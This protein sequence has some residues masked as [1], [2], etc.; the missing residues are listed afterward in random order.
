MAN[1]KYF[2]QERI[3]TEKTDVVYQSEVG[4]VLENSDYRRHITN[5]IFTNEMANTDMNNIQCDAMEFQVGGFNPA[6]GSKYT[7]KMFDEETES[8]G[9]QINDI[10][11]DSPIRSIDVVNTMSRRLNFLD[12]GGRDCI[13]VYIQ[14][15]T[16][17]K[18][19]QDISA[20]TSSMFVIPVLKNRKQFEMLMK[21]YS[22]RTMDMATQGDLE[23]TQHKHASH[24]LVSRLAWVD[25]VKD[26][27]KPFQFP[28]SGWSVVHIDFFNQVSEGG[29]E[30]L[31]NL[32]KN[33][34]ILELTTYLVMVDK[35]TAADLYVN[36]TE[37]G[38]LP[39]NELGAYAASIFKCSEGILYPQ[40]YFFNDG[41]GKPKSKR[42]MFYA[43]AFCTTFYGGKDITKDKK[44]QKNNV[45]DPQIQL[46]FPQNYS[47]VSGG[48]PVTVE[49]QIPYP[50]KIT[51]I[52]GN[53]I[54]RLYPFMWLAREDS[55]KLGLKKMFHIW[56]KRQTQL[57]QIVKIYGTY[58]VEGHLSNTPESPLNFSNLFG[59]CSLVIPQAKSLRHN[60][61]KTAL[62]AVIKFS[63]VESTNAEQSLVY[64]PELITRD[65]LN[66]WNVEKS[67]LSEPMQIYILSQKFGTKPPFRPCSK[68]NI[69]VTLYAYR[70]IKQ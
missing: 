1:I 35:G 15:A 18:G 53:M 30:F 51:D 55:Y 7:S 56:N 23:F 26:S 34:N 42:G 12:D 70:K 11:I 38:G 16:N 58:S 63:L 59:S 2:N 37:D 44:A 13:L 65:V 49:S 54:G 41:W 39:Q 24:A 8:L 47:V 20:T 36:K 27:I 5:A 61:R 6:I 31:R 10:T 14:G 40:T 22:T 32:E 43:S 28:P 19:V 21:A 33:A 66:I 25:I 68:T 67:S 50:A 64:V 57:Q 3:Y 60:M 46:Y 48:Q 4:N 29:A 45:T 17:D 69:A 52:N 62:T 9:I